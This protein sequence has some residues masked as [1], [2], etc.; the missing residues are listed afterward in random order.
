MASIQSI[1][2]LVFPNVGEQDLL[3]PWELLRSVAWDMS[4]RGEKLDVVLGEL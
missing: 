1:A 4:R 3:A 2:F